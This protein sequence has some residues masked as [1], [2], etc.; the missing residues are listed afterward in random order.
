MT[1]IVKPPWYNYCGLS[2]SRY[3]IILIY[4]PSLAPFWKN[5]RSGQQD[6]GQRAGTARWNVEISTDA[7]PFHFNDEQRVVTPISTVLRIVTGCRCGF[8]TVHICILQSHDDFVTVT[9]I[10]SSLAVWY[11]VTDSF[12]HWQIVTPRITACTG[13][14]T[15]WWI[16]VNVLHYKFR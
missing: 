12:W 10:T 3:M 11:T 4:C 2:I 15:S 1:I 6:D 9:R 8:N 14:T 13:V 7:S 16:S 5:W